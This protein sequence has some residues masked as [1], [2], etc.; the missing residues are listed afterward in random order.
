[1]SNPEPRTRRIHLTQ[2][3]SDES[4]ANERFDAAEATLREMGWII[5]SSENVDP[6][7][8]DHMPAGQLP[9]V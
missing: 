8:P 4:F 5:T 6:E 7:V 2:Y 1:M 9:A 3:A